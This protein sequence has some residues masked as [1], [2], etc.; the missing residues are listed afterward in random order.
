VSYTSLAVLSVVLVLLLD[1]IL[2]RT[3][4]VLRLDFWL[5]YAIIV[6]FQA[7]SNGLLT[8]SETVQYADEAILGSGNSSGQPL[9]F[10]GEGRIF[11]A[12]I[13]DLLFGFSFVL[14]TL[15]IW[16]ALGRAGLQRQPQ[17]GPPLW[18]SGSD[19]GPD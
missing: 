9:P 2:L 7:V 11:Y 19:P 16:I 12:P 6:F 4:L 17:A 10:I 15:S 13:E 8:G 14:L 5:A 1:T 3:R 18:Q